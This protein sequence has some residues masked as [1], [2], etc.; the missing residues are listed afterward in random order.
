MLISS[1]SHCVCM[2]F[3]SVT[4]FLTYTMYGHSYNQI[5]YNHMLTPSLF[6]LPFTLSMD[7][8]LPLFYRTDGIIQEAIRKEFIACTVLTIAHRL[9]T[10]MDS[11]RVF[12]KDDSGPQTK[13]G[14][15][16]KK[17]VLC[18]W[19][20]GGMNERREG[21]GGS[22]TEGARQRERDRERDRERETERERQREIETDRERERGRERKG[23]RGKEQGENY[24][25]SF[26]ACLL[27]RWV[28][29]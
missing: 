5:S 24:V 29:L 11:D 16:R 17:R 2:Q 7:L 8:L 26:H 1:E 4:F 25:E 14:E 21:G 27:H 6:S 28:V 19:R 9:N 3:S 13:R 22:E 20:K 15:K 12:V 23:G 10:I 18:R